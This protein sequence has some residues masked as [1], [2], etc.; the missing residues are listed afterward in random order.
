MGFL[1]GLSGILGGGQQT[2][3]TG[4]TQS[5]FSLLP[6]SIQQAYTNYGT[7]VNGQIPNA[8]AAYTPA[9]LSAGENTALTNLTNGFAPTASSLQSDLGML[10]NPF[11]DS[12]I[13]GLN[14]QANSD[15]S[16]LKQNSALNGNFGSNRQQL[17]ANDIENSREANIGQLQQS[18]YNTALGQVFNNLIPQRQQ[19][20]QNALAA[21]TY[22][23]GI[24]DQTNQA[25]I[26]GL[27]QLGAALGILPTS[28]GSNSQNATNSFESKNGTL[29]NLLSTG[30]SILSLF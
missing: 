17:G 15:Y 7:A 2:Q 16:I 27:Q 18:Q 6:Q 25:P 29:G 28:G 26:T 13:N 24:T 9:P 14:R 30:A 19:D 22:Q 23:R 10:Q 20:A 5:G 3:T 8:T 12:V 4:G 1:S 21:G 11:Q